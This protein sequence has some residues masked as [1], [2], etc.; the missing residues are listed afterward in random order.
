MSKSFRQS[1]KIDNAESQDFGE[2][3][4]G[5]GMNSLASHEKT[6]T[7]A[8]IAGFIIGLLIMYITGLLV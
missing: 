1:S 3:T 5:S 4:P 6:S 2:K 7:A 8:I